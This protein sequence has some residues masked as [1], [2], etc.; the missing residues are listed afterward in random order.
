MY[1]IHTHASCIMLNFDIESQEMS[2]Q[3]MNDFNPFCGQRGNVVSESST[4][5]FHH[6]TYGSIYLSTNL[7]QLAIYLASSA[8]YLSI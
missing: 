7:A 6:L 8:S 5:D 3:D 2:T 1:H 4:C